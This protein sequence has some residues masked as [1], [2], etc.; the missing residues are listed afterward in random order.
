MK[1]YDKL[2][3]VGKDNTSIS[4]MAE[5]IA[6]RAMALEDILVES[7]GLVVLFPE[8]VNPKAEAILVSHA[9]S[10]KEHM[11]APFTENEFD[12][13]TLILAVTGEVKQQLERDYENP[14]NVEVL[15]SYVGETE[16]IDNPYGGDLSDYGHCYDRLEELVMKLADKLVKED[17]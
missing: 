2:V 11:S 4:P 13:R 16:D 14:L 6:Q 8:P 1:K 5:A 9:L 3:F 12:E 7:K 17:M 15:C 10:M